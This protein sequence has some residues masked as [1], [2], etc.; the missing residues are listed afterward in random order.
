MSGGSAQP[1][2]IEAGELNQL[3]GLHF[4]NLPFD[5]HLVILGFVSPRDLIALRKVSCL[6]SYFWYERPTFT[7]CYRL[8]RIWLKLYL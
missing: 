7:S 4:L 5:T 1:N 6:K 2:H 8:A 3:E